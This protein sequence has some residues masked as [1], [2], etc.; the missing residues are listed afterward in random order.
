[1]RR[2][3]RLVTALLAALALC[4]PGPADAAVKRLLPSDFVVEGD[5]SQHSFRTPVAIGASLGA[6]TDSVFAAKLSLPAGAEITG[7]TLYSNGLAQPRNLQLMRYTFTPVLTATMVAYGSTSAAQLVIHTPRADAIA[8][9][10]AQAVIQ[11]KALYEVGVL[12][13]PG[14]AVWAVDVAYDPAP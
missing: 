10:P 1:M 4:H 2:P 14:T 13:S 3:L 11:A 9:D 8:I 5:A 6:P 7:I 12:C